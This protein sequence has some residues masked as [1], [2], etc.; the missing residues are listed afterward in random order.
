VDHR[1]YILFVQLL[2]SGCE[3]DR[4]PPLVR[5]LSMSGFMPP[6]SHVCWW[7]MQGRYVSNENAVGILE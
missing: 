6:L 3:S 5:G 4:S 1:T 2:R 7:R